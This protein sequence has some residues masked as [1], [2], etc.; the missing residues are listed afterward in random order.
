MHFMQRKK[1]SRNCCGCP[2]PK[3]NERHWYVVILNVDNSNKFLFT[4]ID[5]KS[6][7]KKKM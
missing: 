7:E 1:N 6:S 5:S 3:E 4:W 2:P